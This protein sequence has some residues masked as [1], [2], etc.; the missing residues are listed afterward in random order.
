MSLGRG[1]VLIRK[2][3]RPRKYATVL[4]LLDDEKILV[5]SVEMH[6]QY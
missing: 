6:E 2:P 4:Q 1:G 5:Y 3:P